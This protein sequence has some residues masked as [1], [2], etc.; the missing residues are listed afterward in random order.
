VPRAED[1]EN[2]NRERA[3]KLEEASVNAAS[4]GLKALLLL[5]G[6][7][8]IALLGFLASTMGKNNLHWGETQFV[9]AATRS[10]GYFAWGAGA[11]VLT[12]VFSYLS[13]QQYSSH[14]RNPSKYKHGWV[15]GD[16]LV[17]G[18]LVCVAASLVLFGLGVYQISASLP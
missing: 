11:S 9:V 2:E 1:I 6:S 17:R 3:N 10:L 12:S 18:G 13:N 14:L 8:C 5:N 15:A 16:W 7:A 4:E